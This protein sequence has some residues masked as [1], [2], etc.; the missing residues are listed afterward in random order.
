MIWTL[1]SSNCRV[2]NG[3]IDH[4][5]VVTSGQQ[6]PQAMNPTMFQPP[7]QPVPAVHMLGPQ[8]YILPASQTSTRDSSPTGSNYSSPL[9]SPL[10]RKKT[11]TAKETDSSSEENDKGECWHHEYSTSLDILRGWNFLSLCTVL[12]C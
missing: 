7:F 3:L 9:P 4:L 6:I 11:V 10:L 12:A 8:Q 1:N 5:V 2:N